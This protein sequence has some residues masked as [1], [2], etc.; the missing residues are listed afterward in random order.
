MP[1]TRP[2]SANARPGTSHPAARIDWGLPHLPSVN[3][4]DR[5]T[6][7]KI[8]QP[9]IK[10]TL[11]LLQLPPCRGQKTHR[12]PIQTLLIIP[13]PPAASSFRPRQVEFRPGRTAL[14]RYP[15]VPSF[16]LAKNPRSGGSRP[17]LPA[18]H[19]TTAPAFPSDSRGCSS[20]DRVCSAQAPVPGRDTLTCG[21]PC[22][23]FSNQSH[24]LF[25]AP[26]K[27]VSMTLAFE[28]HA[29]NMRKDPLDYRVNTSLR[30]VE[31]GH[32]LFP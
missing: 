26:D 30:L 32:I 27:S 10:M 2:G 29:A 14:R 16:S 28:R 25:P 5:S 8:P 4:P 23:I 15:A 19:D 18:A 3:V 9:R 31:G 20:G 13:P 7:P 17:A 11:P 24:R 6:G 22:F 12:R 21:V 1:N